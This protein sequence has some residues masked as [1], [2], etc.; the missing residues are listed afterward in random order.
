VVVARGH[1]G[2]R[3]REIL[4][5]A[6]ERGI[7]V[8]LEE[9]RHLDR[10]AAGGAHQGVV[11][12][13]AAGEYARRSEVLAQL[14]P[15]ALLLVL[16]GIEDPRNLGALLRTAAATGFQGVFVPER[17]A[18]GLTAAVQK[19]SAGTAGVVPVVREKSLIALVKLLKKQGIWVV[20]VD[21]GEAPPWSG[22]DF[23]LP[24]ALVLGGEGRGI[25]SLLRRHCDAAVGLPLRPAVESLNV[26]VAF[27][28]VAYESVRQREGGGGNDRRF[29]G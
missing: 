17:R 14:E 27:G 22:F 4:A 1:H 25:R 23:R 28:G 11:A 6:R 26:S 19:A 12:V 9:R 5:T 16:D 20:G 24:T 2:R 29:V 7:P 8:R 21:A 13:V 10:L 15:P 18:V 3:L